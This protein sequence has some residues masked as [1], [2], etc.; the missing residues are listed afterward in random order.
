MSDTYSNVDGSRDPQE[1]A[2]WQD[3]IDRWPQIQAYKR[4][5][6]ELLSGCT[7]LLDVGCGPS[8]SLTAAGSVSGIGLDASATMCQA[9]RSRGVVVC[10]GTALA[11]P[12]RGRAFAGV[13]ADRVLQ[14]LEDPM[15]ALREVT[16][17]GKSGARLVFAEADQATLAL[18][19]P[20]ARAS[21]VARVVHCRQSFGHHHNLCDVLPGQLAALDVKS[22]Q[23]ESFALVLTD[24]DDAFGI[25]RWPRLWTEAGRAHFDA[26]ELAEWAHAMEAAKTGGFS[27]RVEYKV[28]SGL[29][30]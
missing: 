25:A 30:V 17:V 5:M 8:G 6:A 4:R 2:A 14:H 19:V 3:R 21:L 18:D 1:A 27:L 7:P 28:V 23:V 24:P 9:A 11:L 20:E 22:L 10:R 26:T 16:R 15:A 12:L 13:V 29:R